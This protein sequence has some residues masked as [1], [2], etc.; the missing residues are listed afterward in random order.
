MSDAGKFVSFCTVYGGN[1]KNAGKLLVFGTLGILGVGLLLT[2]CKSTPELAKAN[3]QA[4]IQAKYDQTPAVGA[5]VVVNERG[6][7]QGINA[8]YWERTKAYPNRFW[9]DFGIGPEGKKA[10]KL[11]NGG[12]VIQWRPESEA[13]KNF[14]VIVV[15]TAANHLKARDLQDAQDDG[16]GGKTVEFTEA[17]NLDGVPAPLADIAHNPGNQL[18]AKRHANFAFADGAWKLASIK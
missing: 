9:A 4:L 3:A 15:T 18:S 2:G 1:V 7:L 10:F 17:V 13:D 6:L 12:E 8:K 5:N 14:S 11:A 16:A